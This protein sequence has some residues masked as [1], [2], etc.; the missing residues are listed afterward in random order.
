MSALNREPREFYQYLEYIFLDLEYIYTNVFKVNIQGQ[1]RCIQG[2]GRMLAVGIAERPKV[3]IK[4]CS[5]TYEKM[6]RWMKSHSLQNLASKIGTCLQDKKEVAHKHM[7]ESTLPFRHTRYHSLYLTSTT[8]YTK[9]FHRPERTFLKRK[10]TLVTPNMP[11]A[12][13]T[14]PV[15]FPNQL[16]TTTPEPFMPPLKHARRNTISPLSQSPKLHI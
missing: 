14:T 10:A 7:R 15:S 11:N 1:Y 5:A 4:T 3:C 16:P 6:L 12:H 9:P 13:N 2:I 8:P